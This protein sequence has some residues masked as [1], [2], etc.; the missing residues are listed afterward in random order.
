LLIGSTG[1]AVVIALA[2]SLIAFKLSQNT[3]ESSLQ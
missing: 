3:E 1:I 2:L